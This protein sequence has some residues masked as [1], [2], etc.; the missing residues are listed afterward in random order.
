MDSQHTSCYQIFQYH[1][2]PE[3]PVCGYY[4]VSTEIGQNAPVV[5]EAAVETLA[6][7]FALSPTIP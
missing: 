5:W 7:A 2:E 4:S 3:T 1:R 6:R